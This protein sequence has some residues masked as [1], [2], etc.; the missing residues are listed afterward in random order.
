[1]AATLPPARRHDRDRIREPHEP[2]DAF[3]ARELGFI[4]RSQF[5]LEDRALPDRGVEHIRQM[6]VDPID[7]LA[8]D[9]VQDIEALARRADQFPIPIA[10]AGTGAT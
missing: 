6:H 1:M 10:S 7:R 2:A 8:G 5:A 3:H 9:L 4:D